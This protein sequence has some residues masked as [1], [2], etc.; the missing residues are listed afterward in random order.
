[1]AKMKSKQLALQITKLVSGE[2]KSFLSFVLPPKPRTAQE[3]AQ[4]FTP[5]GLN[6]EAHKGAKIC[7]RGRKPPYIKVN[8]L[9]REIQQV[10]EIMGASPK[11]EWGEAFT[12]PRKVKKN[13]LN[14]QGA[15][16]INKI[17]FNQAVFSPHPKPPFQIKFTL[18]KL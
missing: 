4:V 11:K 1:M 18:Q 3:K 10:K 9:Y 14:S 5:Q 16:A 12:T 13:L 15:A 17:P 2:A 7:I 8:F 6:A